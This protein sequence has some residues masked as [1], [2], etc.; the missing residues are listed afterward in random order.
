[1]KRDDGVAPVIR[2]AEQLLE[3]GLCHFFADGG[4]FC[5]RFAERVFA[6]FILGD[7]KKKPRL[8]ELG[9][10][11][12]PRIDHRFERGLF[13]EYRLG[14]FGVVPEI[15]LG[16]DLVQLLDPFLLAF[17]VKDASAGDRDALRGGSSCS[18]VSS[19]IAFSLSNGRSIT[20]WN[21][22]FNTPR[23]QSWR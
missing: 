3:L 22:T 6:L 10:M 23:S 14:F 13:L 12:F 11:F 21:Y 2:T 7:V 19:N 17:D 8:L 15:R 20:G 18:V 5:C 1:M 4:D 9:A 16:G